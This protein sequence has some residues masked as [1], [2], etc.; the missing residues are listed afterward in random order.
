MSAAGWSS[1][2]VSD[3]PTPKPSI[4]A[5]WVTSSWM[6]CSS[7]LPEAITIASV[8]PD[9]LGFDVELL[10][11]LDRPA[12]PL[13]GVI[14]IDEQDAVVGMVGREASERLT[15]VLE[16]LHVGVGH[17][18][19]RRDR[20]ATPGLDVAGREPAAEVGGERSF[21]AR[22]Q[23]VRPAEPEVRELPT[24]GDKL[25]AGRLG[26]D[27]GRVLDHVHDRGLEQL[28]DGQRCGHLQHRLLGQHD[29]AVRDRPHL[30]GVDLELPELM[31][32]VLADAE[33]FELIE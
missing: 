12:H 14:G 21:D 29:R 22:L 17:G 33:A 24:T 31:A 8:E 32:C 10:A 25:A 5:P 27:Q 23:T 4:G 7:R 6:A 20:I 30:T 26:G 2:T 13:D 28:R 18:P 9:T 1:E 15:L 11:D 3:V 16:G 19:G